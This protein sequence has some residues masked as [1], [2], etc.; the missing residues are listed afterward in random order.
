MTTESIIII[1]LLLILIILL[2]VLLNKVSGTTNSDSN[3]LIVKWLQSMSQNLNQSNKNLSDTLT[4]TT[5]IINKRLDS[6]IGVVA[7]STRELTKMNELSQTIKDLNAVLQAPKLRG[8]LGEEVLA[9]MLAQVFPKQNYQLQYGFSSGARVDAAIKTTAGILPID[10]KFPLENYQ[11]MVKAEVKSERENYLK[12]FLSDVRKHIS[13]IAKKYILVNEGTVDFAFMYVPSEAVFLEVANQPEFMSFARNLR[14]YPVS[15]NTLYAHLQTVLLSFEGQK[16]EKSAK[17]I[18]ALF[19]AL[20]KDYDKTKESI[21][22]LG[23]HLNNASGQYN[24]AYSQMS[25]MG[26]KLEGRKLLEE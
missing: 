19:K 4:Q 8:N 12:M 9:D 22:I 16:I 15:P 24:N 1:G 23:K 11:K 3:N 6:A 5:Q 18:L 7:D 2:I 17:Q 26:Q 14:V 20:Q 25:L 21:E 10:A 13:D